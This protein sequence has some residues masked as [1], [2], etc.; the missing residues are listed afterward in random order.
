MIF[1]STGFQ[2]AQATVLG[3]VILHPEQ[4]WQVFS[5]VSVSDFDPPF[6][7]VAAAIEGLRLSRTPIDQLAVI[8]EL[9]RRST[10][11]RM[12]GP[13]EVYRI[14]SFGFGSA[15]YAIDHI[16]RVAQL[17]RLAMIGTRLE[18]SVHENDAEPLALAKGTVARA[19][20]IIDYIEATAED[21]DVRSVGELLAADDEPYDWVI[22]GLL[23]RGD[24]LVLT[25]VEGVGKS[26]LFRQLSVTAAAGM[27]PFTHEAIPQQHV[28]LVDCENG[29]KHIRRQIRSLVL[30][31]IQSGKDPSNHLLIEPV[32]SGLDLTRPEDEAWLVRR[33]STL[34][35]SMLA[36]GPLYRLHAGNPNDEEQARQVAA[37]L[38]R[39]RAA[40]NCAVILEAHAGHSNG[41][42]KERPVRPVGS[43]LW[44]RW[45][46]FGYGLRPAEGHN[47]PSYRKVEVVSWR[48]DRE[49]RDWPAGLVSGGRMPWREEAFSPSLLAVPDAEPDARYGD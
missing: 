21:V 30:A 10:L 22:P 19:Q 33:V 3:T 9:E 32:P 15:E 49:E 47:P 16:V 4:A 41:F 18:Q 13:A 20:E 2:I 11:S 45:P 46:E 17:R 6:I 1:D 14:A 27:H 48:G 5:R 36:I 25:G 29:R 24:R 35:P 39:C 43:S 42:S 38:D 7:H 44:L 31:G 28:L 26:M 40:A 8:A 23:E 12:G 37:V 34:Q